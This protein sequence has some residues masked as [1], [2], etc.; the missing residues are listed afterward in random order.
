MDIWL[1]IPL[2]QHCLHELE[3]VKIAPSLRQGQKKKNAHTHSY[4]ERAT[5]AKILI[6]QTM[7]GILAVLEH[8]HPFIGFCFL[9]KAPQQTKGR[10]EI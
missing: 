8:F 1:T 10:C 6:I 7:S 2:S 9:K 5:R 4:E 3:E